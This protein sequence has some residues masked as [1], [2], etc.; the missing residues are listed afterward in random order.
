ME[1]KRI[2]VLDESLRVLSFER[3]LNEIPGKELSLILSGNPAI[4]MPATRKAELLTKLGALMNAPSL[5]QILQQQLLASEITA[6]QLA[7]NINLP[8]QV[9]NDLLDDSIYTNNVPIVLL[10]NLLYNLG[11]SFSTAEKGIRKTFELLQSKFSSDGSSYSLHPAFRSGMFMSKP[12]SILPYAKATDG[13]EL[14]ENKEAI[15]KYLSR[16]SELLNH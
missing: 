12:D 4:E 5:G 6:D 8:T 3:T 7:A 2:D 9:V 11:I 10:R 15:E 1:S 13:K 16:L 14:Y